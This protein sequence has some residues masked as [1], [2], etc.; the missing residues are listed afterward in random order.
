[1]AALIADMTGESKAVLVAQITK[2][3]AYHP[4]PLRMVED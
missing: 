3:L 1:M 4:P 2:G